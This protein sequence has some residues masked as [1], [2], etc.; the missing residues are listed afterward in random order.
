MFVVKVQILHF[1]LL[2]F[3][4]LSFTSRPS[5][6]LYGAIY[7]QKRE[8]SNAGF[9]GIPA[10]YPIIRMPVSVRLR[11]KQISQ[12]ILNLW[13][14]HAYLYSPSCPNGI[15]LLII[16]VIAKWYVYVFIYTKMGIK[17]RLHLKLWLKNVLCRHI[18]HGQVRHNFAWRTW[19]LHMY[20]MSVTSKVMSVTVRQIRHAQFLLLINV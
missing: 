4:S 15:A 5:R 19:L 14:T 7:C 6:N 2:F 10:R 17:I 18:R 12:I 3:L 20:V 11:G 8:H 9:A 1:C 16:M 13:M